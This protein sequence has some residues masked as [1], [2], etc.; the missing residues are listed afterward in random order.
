MCLCLDMTEETLMHL[1]WYCPFAFSCWNL[2]APN[3]QRG[4]SSYD[5]IQLTSKVLPPDMRW[6]SSL[7]VPVVFGV[8][9]M[10]RFSGTWQH[11]RRVGDF[12]SRKGLK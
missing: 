8:L 5:E 4:I 12:I 7:W 11:T 6:I 3:K 9:E 2:I 1:F 10:L